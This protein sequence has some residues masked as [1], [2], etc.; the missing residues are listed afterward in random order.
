MPRLWAQTLMRTRL[1]RHW[2]RG[3]VAVGIGEGV[4]YRP[5]LSSTCLSV[6]LLAAFGGEE[7]G[8]DQV[9]AV[10]VGDVGG[11]DRCGDGVAGGLGEGEGDGGFFEQ[12]PGKLAGARQEVGIG[13]DMVGE[14]PGEGFGG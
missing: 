11:G 12:C 7:T 3:Y 14:A 9:L 13:D 8:E 10:A 6:L 2:G 4:A 5:P 1:R